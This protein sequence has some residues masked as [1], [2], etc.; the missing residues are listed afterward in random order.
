[1]SEEKLAADP[2]GD[3]NPAENDGMSDKGEVNVGL[4]LRATRE[5][6]GISV[7]E[8]ASVL[9]LSPRQVEALEANDWS[10]CR[11]R[12]FVDLCATTRALSAWMSRR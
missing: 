3:R 5:S 6:K 9:K 1:M 4:Q 7:E 12:S 2:V 8:V 10:G 11:K